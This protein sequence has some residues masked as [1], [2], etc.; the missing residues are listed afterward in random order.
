MLKKR[1]PVL[2]LF[3]L[4][5]FVLPA[6]LA[7]QTPYPQS[8]T[9]QKV[10]SN[11]AANSTA[12]PPVNQIIVKFQDTAV[13]NQAAPLDTDAI[14]SRLTEVAGVSLTYARPMSGDAHVLQLAEAVPPLEAA[15]IA[16][17][18]AALPDVEYA[19][20]DL[21]KQIVGNH[22]SQP[23][24]PSLTPNDPRFSD[25][26]H[27]GYTAN[28]AEGINVV[29]AWDVT[30]GISSTIVAVID[31]GIL[32]HADLAGRT[33]PGYDFISDPAIANDG[34]GRDND[35]SDPGD[36]TVANE[37]FTGSSPRDSSWHG[38]HVAGTIGAAT[39]N[40]TGVAGINWNAKILPIRVLGTC[41]G[42]TSD[43]VDAIRWAA[44]LTVSGAPANVNP[45]DVINMSLGGSGICSTSEQNAINDAVAA[46]TT[47]VVAAGNSNANAANFSPASCSNVI[48]VAATDRTGDR[49]F[50]SNFGSVVEVS[51]PGGETTT[52]ANGVLSTLDSGTTVP[53]NDNAYTYYQGTSMAAPHVA[54]VASLIIG[55]N[56]GISPAQVLSTLQLT[57]RSFPSGSG[58]TTSNCGSGIVDAYRALTTSFEQVYLPVIVRGNNTTGGSFV[59]ADFENGST[60]WTEFSQQGVL[61]L[62]VDA[63]TLPSGVTPHSGSKAVWLGGL[64]DEINYIEQTVT[65]PTGSPYLAY[66]HWIASEDACGYDFGG[67]VING[68]AVANVYDLCS[69]ANTGGWQHHV[70]NLSAYVGQTVAIQI[71]AE[72]DSSLNSNLFV[73][74]VS[75][76][77]SPTTTGTAV[78]PLLTPNNA[79][80]PKP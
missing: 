36:W 76:Q 20:P 30:T 32:A 69:S 12:V 62:I 37:C 60:G 41:G 59:N 6:L 35:P 80:A 16:A 14:M 34:G 31:T 71:R 70:V 22:T 55:E 44:G 26:W 19:E 18:L 47:V 45:A 2:V 21:I 7:A 15:A 58:C 48:T 52:T 28:T 63:A 10:L 66:W 72:T 75:F 68:S 79:A 74:D 17:R 29:A 9:S 38:T 5:V 50:Y 53:A 11:V 56:P 24:S 61:P 78:P 3:T 13:T 4:F 49:A 67:V 23:Q 43:I 65:V 73:D 51:A 25:Q 8:T 77:S 54:G 42:S 1:V 27:Y 33:V 64:I 57:A 40:G 39:N 46:G